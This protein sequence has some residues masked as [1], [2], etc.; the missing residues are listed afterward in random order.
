MVVAK[1]AVIAKRLR[2]PATPPA[3]ELAGGEG[4]EI[5]ERWSVQ[6]KTELVLR[7]LRGEALNAVSRESQIPAHA[8]ESWKRVFPETGTRGLKT[9]T[10]PEERE[11]T[12]TR[13]KI[14][15]LT[16]R[17]ELAE[18]LIEKRRGRINHLLCRDAS[19]PAPGPQPPPEA[20]RARTRPRGGG[21]MGTRPAPESPAG[22][23]AAR[24]PCELEAAGRGGGDRER[25][26]TTPDGATRERER[27][28]LRG[29]KQR[30]VMGASVRLRQLHVPAFY[31]EAA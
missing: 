13:A 14:G 1:E 20:Q 2:K 28:R 10:E 4:P 11:L 31:A 29:V 15:E 3:G 30:R 18:H 25:G 12:L 5:P 24:V 7:L 9:R 19:T 26:Q 6:R 23:V 17:L 16:M 27:E 21:R 8:L 22:S